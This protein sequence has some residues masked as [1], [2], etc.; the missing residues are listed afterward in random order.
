MKEERGAKETLLCGK[1]FVFHSKKPKLH[2]LNRP[3]KKI[4]ARKGR[5]VEGS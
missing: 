1:K 5:N 2:Y 3:I 4:N